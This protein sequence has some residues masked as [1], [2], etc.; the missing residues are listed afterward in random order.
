[1]PPSQG[2][3]AL[4]IGVDTYPESEDIGDLSGC[5]N[6]ALLMQELLI[7]KFGVPEEKITFLSSPAP[8]GRPDNWASRDRIIKGF[9]DLIAEAREGDM[10]V[11]YFAGHGSQVKDRDM[12]EGSGHDSTIMPA[13]CIRVSSKNLHHSEDFKDITDDEIHLKLLELGMR[14]E[15]ITLIFDSCHSGNPPPRPGRPAY[16]GAHGAR[17]RSA[18]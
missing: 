4:I 3:L 7:D 18:A 15:N 8:E 5:V 12:D 10:V 9:D 16:G 1:M 11:V 17:R 13:D 6:D 14:T 2:K